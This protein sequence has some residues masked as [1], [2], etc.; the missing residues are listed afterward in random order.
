VDAADPFA[1]NIVSGRLHCVIALDWGEEIDLQQAAQLVQSQA[2]ILPRRRRTPETIAYRPTPLRFNL[3]T[4]AVPLP[5]IGSPADVEAVVFD[6]GAV[7]VAF[8]V[9]F[10]MTMAA[11]R[12]LAVTLAEPKWLLPAAKAAVETLHQQLLPAIDDPDWSGFNEEYFTFQ[13]DPH[14]AY[15]AAG[16]FNPAYAPWLA[17]LLRLEDAELSAEE[18]SDALRCR[19]SYGE[20]DIVFVDWSAAVVIDKDCEETLHTIEFANLQLLEYRFLDQKV[21]DALAAA[22]KQM[23]AAS[24]SWLQF[25]RWHT[26]PLR[27]LSEIRMDVVGTLE[28]AS[29]VLQLVGDQYLSR[30]YRLLSER[31]HLRQW[32]DNVRQALDV[33]EGVHQTLSS[34][35]SMYR[36]ELLELTVVVLILIEL[37]LALFAK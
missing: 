34:Q 25:W 14:E 23:Q 11:L 16:G 20:R 19:I 17:G 37:L 15:F 24:R 10:S 33:A 30:L 27:T 22:R 6:F 35:S 21:D 2:G 4:Q 1:T 31:F 36:L 13:L 5:G 28:R 32:A 18:A 3:G 7:N 8:R 9:P 29:G 26:R 12:H